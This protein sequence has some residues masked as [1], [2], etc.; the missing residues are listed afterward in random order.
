ML[1]R[2][3]SKEEVELDGGAGGGL[4]ITG[5]GGNIGKFQFGF[6][7]SNEVMWCGTAAL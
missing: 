1:S 7:V 2:Y 3:R 6:D 4:L 5:G